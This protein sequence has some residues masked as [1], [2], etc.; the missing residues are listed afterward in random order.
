MKSTSKYYA[1]YNPQKSPPST[2]YEKWEACQQAI[3]GET[4][5]SYKAFKNKHDATLFLN[6]LEITDKNNQKK[7]Q[8][9]TSSIYLDGSFNEKCPYSAWAWALVKDDALILEKSGLCPTIHESRN[10]DGEIE[11]ALQAS[12]WAKKHQKQVTLHY[13][14][15]GIRSWALGL[16]KRNT[17]LTEGYHEKIQ[18]ALP[19]LSFYKVKS[20]SG[21]KWNDHVDNLAKQAIKKYLT[22]PKLYQ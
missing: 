7:V 1:V 10:I 4:G 5:I 8:E 21:N 22:N 17:P 9:N 12:E 13:D 6:Q 16:W 11:A 19:Y 14:Y 18:L 15:E 2:I 20:H 3:R